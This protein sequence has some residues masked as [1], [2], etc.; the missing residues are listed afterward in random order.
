[1][2]MPF[3]KDRITLYTVS[4]FSSGPAG[5]LHSS[6]HENYSMRELVEGGWVQ[7]R[8]IGR[9]SHSLISHTKGARS[10]R[11]GEG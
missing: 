2:A 6:L 5:S 11:E 7:S 8:T 3:H 10:T 9:A 4:P 1:M